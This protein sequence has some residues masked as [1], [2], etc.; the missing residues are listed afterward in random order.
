M[1]KTNIYGFGY[2]EPGDL[3]SE[4]LD[5]DQR[6][7]LAIENNVQHLYAIFGNGVIEESGSSEPSWEIQ[8][9]SSNSLEVQISIGQGHVAWKYCKTDSVTTVSLPANLLPSKF[10]IY[11][12]PNETSPE[13]GTVTFIASLVEINNP[14]YYVGLG[15]VTVSTGKMVMIFQS[16]IMQKM[17]EL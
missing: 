12:T 5:L 8:F 17:A 6:R 16:A 9:S 10:W 3:T 15:S 11:A 13:L 14:N 4:L 7:F 1:K 2:L